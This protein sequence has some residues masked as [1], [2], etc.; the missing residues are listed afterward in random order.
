MRA[1]EGRWPTR[2]KAAVVAAKEWHG[3]Q[4]GDNSQQSR[5]ERML[6]Q[7]HAIECAFP[8]S[9][10]NCVVDPSRRWGYRNNAPSSSSLRKNGISLLNLLKEE[11][12]AWRNPGERRCE[13]AVDPLV[14]HGR[15]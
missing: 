11:L 12:P 8:V 15:A 3:R 5:H 14:M 7:V 6:G 2:R 13:S 10:S 4:L 9:G 1:G